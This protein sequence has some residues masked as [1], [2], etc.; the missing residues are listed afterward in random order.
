M[1]ENPETT[2]LAFFNISLEPI[3]M[4]YIPALMAAST[5]ASASSKTIH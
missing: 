4:Q 3:P 2:K 5:P 1:S